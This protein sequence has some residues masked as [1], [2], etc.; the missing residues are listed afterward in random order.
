[1]M[2]KTGRELFRLLTTQYYVA[3]YPNLTQEFLS[4]VVEKVSSSFNVALRARELGFG[5]FIHL[6]P[7]V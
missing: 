3:N 1:M 2:L 4:R 6:H 5:P 7:R